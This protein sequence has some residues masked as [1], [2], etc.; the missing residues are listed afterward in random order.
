MYTVACRCPGKHGKYRFAWGLED[1]ALQLKLLKA[2]FCG[3]ALWLV[4]TSW[5]S[6]TNS[7]E[8]L[9]WAKRK[10]CQRWL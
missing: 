1:R 5:T 2:I 3:E 10:K 9:P 6:C 7:S 4:S 8:A